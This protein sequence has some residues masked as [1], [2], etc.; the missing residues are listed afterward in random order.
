MISVYLLPNLF[1]GVNV[2][3]FAIEYGGNVNSKLLDEI[4]GVKVVGR[5]DDGCSQK[6]YYLCEIFQFQ[7]ERIVFFPRVVQ[8]L[9]D[10]HYDLFLIENPFEGALL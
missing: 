6:V 3:S 2:C 5:S 4:E 10:K 9:F 1:E 8:Y 7:Y